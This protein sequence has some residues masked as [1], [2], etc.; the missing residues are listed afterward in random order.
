[1]QPHDDD[2]PQTPFSLTIPCVHVYEAR[3]NYWAGRIVQGITS[4]STTATSATTEPP[5]PA[6]LYLTRHEDRPW[7]LTIHCHAVTGLPHSVEFTEGDGPLWSFCTLN[8]RLR[9]IEWPLLVKD[10]VSCD[11]DNDDDQQKEKK[12]T[13]IYA[14]V[15]NIFSDSMNL[16]VGS[17]NG[18]MND[19]LIWHHP[20][21]GGRHGVTA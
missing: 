4:S 10:V 9:R 13:T 11:N 16:T 8:E 17:E 1:M 5:S 19:M 15:E 14:R 18:L 12:T 20:P 2:E 7:G 6:S 3:N 21:L